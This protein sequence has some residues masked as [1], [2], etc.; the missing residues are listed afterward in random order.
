MKFIFCLVFISGLISPAL[1]AAADNSADID[2][3]KV[4]IENRDFMEPEGLQNMQLLSTNLDEGTKSY[5]YDGFRKKTWESFLSL[6]VPS[7]GNWLTGDTTGG[8]I[9]LAG[10]AGGIA[11]IVV[12][13][14]TQPPTETTTTTATSYHVEYSNFS[15]LVPIGILL[16]ICADIYGTGSALIDVLIYNHGLGEGLDMAWNENSDNSRFTAYDYN[17]RK[18]PADLVHLDLISCRF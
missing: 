9:S 7:L 12:G 15:P 5:L 10:A 2:K 6:P 1:S 18:E 14:T 4:M 13:N 11:L 17:D 3:I 16:I 8:I